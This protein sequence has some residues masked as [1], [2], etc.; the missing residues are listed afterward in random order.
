M[1][2]IDDCTR[3]TWLYQLKHKDDMFS[4]FQSFYTMILIQ[5]S[6]K[7]QILRSNNGGEYVNKK[8]QDYFAT[9]GL[10]H[11]TSCDQTPQQNGVTERKNRLILEIACALLLGAHMLSR[12]WDDAI[13]RAVYLL[14][15]MP[16]KSGAVQGPIAGS[17]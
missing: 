17:F 12:Y 5:F 4:V 1:T 16:S 8:F 10:L 13:T 7:I 11:E 3:M 14:N 2:F 6:A 15:H 9:H